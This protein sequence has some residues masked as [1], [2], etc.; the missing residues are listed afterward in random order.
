ML[1]PE[2]ETGSAM[3]PTGKQG[4]QIYKPSY[5]PLANNSKTDQNSLYIYPVVMGCITVARLATVL[6]RK[7]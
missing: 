3:Q 5:A 1:L 4:W 2:T 7:K 6:I